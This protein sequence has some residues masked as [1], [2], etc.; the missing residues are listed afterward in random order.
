M[1]PDCKLHP[2][3]SPWSASWNENWNGLSFRSSHA[4]ANN[5][6]VESE[7][8]AIKF[9]AFKATCFVDCEINEMLCTYVNILRRVRE[10]KNVKNSQNVASFCVWQFNS[11]KFSQTWIFFTNF[12]LLASQQ[13]DVYKHDVVVAFRFHGKI[14]NLKKF[15]LFFLPSPFSLSTQALTYST[16]R[17]YSFIV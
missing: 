1:S 14:G 5:V 11:E 8:K 4:I 13:E 16:N 9:R 15:D 7:S 12:K 17:I 2:V 6:V 3:R 10:G